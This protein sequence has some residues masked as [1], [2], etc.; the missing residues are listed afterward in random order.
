MCKPLPASA[1]A[2]CLYEA[3][4][5]ELPPVDKSVTAVTA[6]AD[7]SGAALPEYM[8]VCS[9]YTSV[10]N[11]GFYR[12]E[13]DPFDDFVGAIDA[14]ERVPQGSIRAGSVL[15][16]SRPFFYGHAFTNRGGL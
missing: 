10:P 2:F 12:S 14:P 1:L 15:D 3:C 11:E 4:P 8:G 13:Y 5:F 6:P 9:L 7:D 16:W